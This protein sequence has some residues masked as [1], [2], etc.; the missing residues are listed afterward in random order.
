MDAAL[1]IDQQLVSDALSSLALNTLNAFQNG[2]P[3]KWHDAELAVYIV[4]IFGE[5]NKS[6]PCP[7]TRYKRYPADWILAGSK[8]RAAFCQTPAN[9]AKEKRKETNYSEY[10]LTRHG[11]MIYALMQSGISSYPHKTVAMQFFETAARY[12]DFF[13][14]RKECIVPTLQ[15]MLDTRY[16]LFHL[17]FP[18]VLMYCYQGTS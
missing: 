6:T 9:I 5:I 16:F 11:E 13:K 4:F 14:V 7:F 12:G 8:G 18:V 2:V 15:A 1:V 3:V 10:P 17:P